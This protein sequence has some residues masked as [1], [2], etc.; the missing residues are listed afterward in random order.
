MA[1]IVTRHERLFELAKLRWQQ[2]RAG[3]LVLPKD[4]CAVIAGYLPAKVLLVAGGSALVPMQRRPRRD[5]DE[6]KEE[7]PV[8]PCVLAVD[9]DKALLPWQPIP[10]RPSARGRARPVLNVSLDCDQLLWAWDELSRAWFVG[11]FR[12]RPRVCSDCLHSS[13]ED[14]TKH[15]CCTCPVFL[16]VSADG[17]TVTS[18]PR[19]HYWMRNGEGEDPVLQGAVVC[20]SA[21]V[22][23]GGML[24]LLGGEVLDA[25]YVYDGCPTCNVPTAA[26]YVLHP[27]APE[28]R[29]GPPMPAGRLCHAAAAVDGRI[30]VV[31]GCNGDGFR[32]Y[33]A[34]KSVF[35]LPSATAD[36][37]MEGPDLPRALCGADLSVV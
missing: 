9:V 22:C 14:A 8:D 32:G 34:V 17:C 11:A 37:W 25:H 31:G 12:T 7:E 4:V 16:R 29:Q 27:D 6:E 24:W 2:Q 36:E 28:W 26:T 5:A 18:L 20:H 35:W 15:C 13:D 23:V 10:P 30:A 21:L 3:G 19:V 33:R 1:A